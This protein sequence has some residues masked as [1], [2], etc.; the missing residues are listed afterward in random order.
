MN[1]VE[2]T[3]ILRKSLQWLMLLRAA[4]ATFLL[5]ATAYIQSQE[6][7]L[8][9]YPS[10]CYIY[11]FIGIVYGLTIIYGFLL[12]RFRNLRHVA[13][14]QI[15]GDVVFVTI[16]IYLTGGAESIF[17][18]VYLLP[19]ISASIVLFRRGGLII[20]SLSTI[21]FGALLDLEYYNVLI[22]LG[23]KGI[24]YIAHDVY[25]FFY[26]LIM[27]TGMF[28]L[29]AMLSSNVAHRLE[30]TESELEKKKV[31]Y[32]KLEALYSDIVENV[33]SGLISLD[34]DG[35][36]LFLNK[37]GEKVLGQRLGNVHKRPIDEVFPWVD[38]KCTDQMRGEAA[39]KRGDGKDV[40]LGYSIS[41]SR[42]TERR[43][44]VFQDITNIK[45]MEEQIVRSERLAA[46]GEMAAGVAH[47]IRNPIASISGSVEML[48]EELIG[49]DR[50]QPLMNIVLRETD[51]LNRFVSD[52]LQFTK[53]VV[54]QRK[55]FLLKDLVEDVLLS[56]KTSPG[57]NR[58]IE[59]R[60]NMPP[61]ISVYADSEQLRQVLLNLL[62]NAI[63]AMPDCGTLSVSATVR[64]PSSEKRDGKWRLEHGKFDG[65]DYIEISVCD[66]GIGVA[67]ENLKKVFDPF[68]TTKDN[69]TG[70]GLSIVHQIV[71][72][73]QGEVRMKSQQDHGTTVIM[74]LPHHD[75]NLS[76]HDKNCHE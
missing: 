31:D 11:T 5:G 3:E 16:L 22:P 46:I 38:L 4:I 34:K 58:G 41:P 57:W 44:M 61:S 20:A 64:G 51:R 45:E 40:F 55:F 73:H 74:R 43:I 35:H 21:L 62:L 8:Y 71:E 27:N 1:A 17:S 6:T 53:P 42:D 32:S 13:Y 76:I 36:I 60:M 26:V 66:T 14:F 29:V 39:W 48:K 67:P 56:I 69:G 63:Q 72:N 47:E 10:L 65:G 52:F 24:E 18:F 15:S 54:P 75:K 2:Q 49:S 37:A 23:K 19:I 59:V 12:P 7:Y 33:N 28:F 25:Y 70:L 68:F 9:L 30:K 50:T